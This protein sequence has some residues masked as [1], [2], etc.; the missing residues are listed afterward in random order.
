MTSFVRKES[1]R[2]NSNS[3][4]PN[5]F[6]S[7]FHVGDVKQFLEHSG[8][9]VDD[10]EFETFL[11]LF[12]VLKKGVY[13]QIQD[14]K[15]KVFLPF[16]NANYRNDWGKLLRTKDSDYRKV[17][18]LEKRKHR[19]YDLE[20]YNT[21]IAEDPTTWYANYNM[22]RNT[23]Y[24]NGDLKD[25]MDEGDK[26][27]DNFYV[28]FTE[29]CQKRKIKD[30][31]IFLNPRDY[32][33]LRKDFTH[34]YDILYQGKV[35]VCPELERL[36]QNGHTKIFSQSGSDLYQD[37]LMP[38]DDDIVR[39]I[40]N[41][42]RK[43]YNI[44]WESK[45]DIAIFRGSATGSGINENS[46]ARLRLIKF[47][48]KNKDL[49]IDAKLTG[50]NNRLKLDPVLGYCDYIDTR[51]FQ[52]GQKGEFMSQEEQSNYKYIIHVEG[53]VAAFRLANE[54]AYGSLILKVD[55][56]WKTWY[57][58]FLLGYDPEKDLDDDIDFNDY[59][60]IS[61]KSDLSNLRD[62]LVWCKK[63][64]EKCKIIARNAYNF[65]KDHLE[66]EKF[67]LNYMKYQ[68]DR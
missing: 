62:I 2:V 58:D 9:T 46:N 22:F 24:E 39:I 5:F 66:N 4:Y 43:R 13:V 26:S 15:L 47:V 1:E 19:N 30:T 10:P 38:D 67:M 12:D 34:P 33:V 18:E 40:K 41:K 11:Y 51:R 29:L 55:S 20:K 59:H 60:Y 16:S 57:S 14:N 61:I 48:E 35:P 49:N 21:K 44:N 28:L 32:P 6:Q 23:V 7:I 50:F 68:L 31:K 36:K 53:H 64:D 8:L 52:G 56:K 65:Y 54:M 17:V 45:K 37:I 42:A 63:N 27:I 25:L 3:K